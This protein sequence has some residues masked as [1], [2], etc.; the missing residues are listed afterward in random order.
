M[1]GDPVLNDFKWEQEY[2]AKLGTFKN[3]INFD[4]TSNGEEI[5][6]YIDA[7]LLKFES[8]EHNSEVFYGTFFGDLTNSEIGLSATVFQAHQNFPKAIKIK[9]YL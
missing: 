1:F 9:A 4:K 8:N 3:G 6:T 7:N 5:F 2:L